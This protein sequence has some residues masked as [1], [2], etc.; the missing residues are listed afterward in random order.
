MIRYGYN[1]QVE[2]P[3]PFVYVTLRCRETGKEL[4]DLPAQLD[5]AADR[6]AVPGRVVAEL[7]LVRLDE[8]SVS[9]FGGEVF[10]LPTYRVELG[11]HDLEPIPV[12]VLAYPQEPFILLG[13]DVLN[14]HRMV[15]D[16]PSLKL[17]I[18]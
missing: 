12:E 13:R 8:L 6:T 10:L 4:T 3:A 5:S 7:G 9:G 17:E 14:Q 18:D 16:G 15:H 11:L 2:P 1:Q